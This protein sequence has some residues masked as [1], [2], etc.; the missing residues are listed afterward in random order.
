MKPTMK[1]LIIGTA[2]ALMAA[3]PAAA[4]SYNPNYGTG[5][6]INQDLAE[7]TNGALAI[8]A[9]AV[10]APSSGSSAYAY[11]PA[12]RYHVQQQRTWG[13]TPY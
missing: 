13:M 7:R 4:Q 6:A 10:Y 3:A 2:L 12:P 9:G 1:K 5:N 8:G 11:A